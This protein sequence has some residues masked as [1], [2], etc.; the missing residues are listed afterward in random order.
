[1]NILFANRAFFILLLNIILALSVFFIKD[2]FNYFE[3]TYEKAVAFFPVLEKDISEIKIS[4]NQKLAVHLKKNDK[5]WSLLVKEQK[6]EANLSSVNGLIKSLLNAK[7]FTELEKTPDDDLGLRNP[8]QVE[9]FSKNGTLGSVLIGSTA[10]KGSYTY[11]QDKKNQKIYLVE[12]NLKTA[13]GRGELDSFYNKR[14]FPE[15]LKEANSSKITTSKKQ[16]EE[17]SFSLE[18]ENG[19]WFFTHLDEKEKINKDKVDSLLS[20]FNNLLA[21]K[22]VF[23]EDLKDL[24][25]D[26]SQIEIGY[27]SQ[28]VQIQSVGKNKD[29]YYLKN[30]SNPFFIYEISKYSFDSILDKKKE[31]FIK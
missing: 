23:E 22:I 5:S 9:L 17:N 12:D 19:D 20:E 15:D 10:P 25:L 18:K 7:K 31:F 21:V 8:I 6:I 29:N 27:K 2:P 24:E 14:L 11:V 26:E 16:P 1:M 13:V 4:N 3:K 28:K 30:L